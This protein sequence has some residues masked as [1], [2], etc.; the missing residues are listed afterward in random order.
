VPD[1]PTQERPRR[2]RPV[3]LA[4]LAAAALLVALAG[5]GVGSGGSAGGSSDRVSPGPPAADQQGQGQG[6]TRRGRHCHHD[7]DHQGPQQQPSSQPPV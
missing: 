4:M 5:S 6:L 2:R 1:E 7:R 3:L